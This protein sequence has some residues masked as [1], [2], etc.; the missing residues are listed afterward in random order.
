LLFWA[1]LC[2]GMGCDEKTSLK[3]YNLGQLCS[4]GVLMNVQSESLQRFAF[5]LFEESCP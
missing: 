1:G 3:G 4:T 2:F 5:G